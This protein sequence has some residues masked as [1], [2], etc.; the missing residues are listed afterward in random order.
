METHGGFETL[1][2]TANGVKLHAKKCGSG[3]PCFLLH[4]YPQTWH[5]WRFAMKA[6]A[7]HFTV[8]APDFRGWG[9]SEKKPPYHLRTMVD[10]TLCLMDALEIKKAHFVGHDWGAAAAYLIARDVPERV[11]KLVTVNMPVKRFD[12]TKTLHFYVF[13]MMGVPEILMKI[14]SDAVVK[15]IMRWWAHNHDAFPDEVLRVYQDAAGKPGAN[16]ATLG[17]YRSSLRSMM[18]GKNKL[19]MGPLFKAVVPAVPWQALWGDKDSV[20][21][22]KNVEYFKEDAPGVPVTL[23]ENAGH[24]P[25]EEQ[26]ETFNKH[27][28]EFLRM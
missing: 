4:G 24:F 20:S 10:D 11:E 19:K 6:L 14:N 16:K 1:F 26:P 8:Y 27:L 23:I 15:F 21:P 22:L 7:P 5:T 3:A 17:Y 2:V 9:K 13:N 18:F 28:L 12:W 25:Q